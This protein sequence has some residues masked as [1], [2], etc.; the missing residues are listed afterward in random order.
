MKMFKCG[1]CKTP[2]K[3]DETKIQS[4]QLTV[5]CSKCG[6][7]NVLRFGPL[8]IAQSKDSLQQVSLK[9]GANTI[10]RKTDNS[11]CDLMLND[12]YVSKQHATVYIE[13]LDNKL[14]ISFVDNGSLNG[15]FT[16][17]KSKL[18]KGLKYPFLQDE[19]FIVGLTK[20]TLKLN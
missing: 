2:Y 13:N 14:Y 20:L 18:K 16:K 9:M 6:S 19:Y 3:I 8:L 7:K 15:T 5:N 11:K 4:T 1:S 17:T 12:E 10:G